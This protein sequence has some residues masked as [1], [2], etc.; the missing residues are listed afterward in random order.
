[1]E[2]RDQIRVESCHGTK[3]DPLWI[4]RK[5]EKIVRTAVFTSLPEIREIYGGLGNWEIIV[6][7][8][9]EE[10]NAYLASRV[11]ESAEGYACWDLTDADVAIEG[12]GKVE[13]RFYP[14]SGE[15]RVYKSQIYITKIDDSITGKVGESPAESPY[16]DYLEQ[17][18]SLK[19]E[20]DAFKDE[21]LDI[22]A[23]PS[24]NGTYVLSVTVTDGGSSYNWIRN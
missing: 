18:I 17:L 24:E 20:I 6:E 11:W 23:P 13:L 4:G 8:P 19:Q 22:P 15:D 14:A 9:T 10:G 5:G 21:F 7:R 2:V 1:M 16:E 12:N 3:E